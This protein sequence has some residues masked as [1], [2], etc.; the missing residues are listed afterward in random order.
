MEFFVF[1][2]ILDFGGKMQEFTKE[3][4]S[5]KLL[6]IIQNSIIKNPVHFKI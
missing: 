1:V 4:K 6:K 5:I 2:I 3:K